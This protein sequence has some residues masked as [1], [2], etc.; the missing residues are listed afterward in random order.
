VQDKSRDLQDIVSSRRKETPIGCASTEILVKQCFHVYSFSSVH[1][2]GFAFRT[3]RINGK[4]ELHFRVGVRRTGMEVTWHL[5]NLAKESMEFKYVCKSFSVFQSGESEA[6]GVLSFVP[7]LLQQVSVRPS[8]RSSVE[9][10]SENFFPPCSDCGGR[11][12][13]NCGERDDRG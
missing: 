4:Q 9:F 10:L 8:A 5:E 6:V 2:I 12:E 11:I 3:F 7:S 13:G 1:L